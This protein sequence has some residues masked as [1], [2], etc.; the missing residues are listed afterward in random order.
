LFLNL[1]TAEWDFVMDEKQDQL[2]I[3]MSFE[4]IAVDYERE[5]DDAL[6]LKILNEEFIPEELSPPIVR[7][8]L[9]ECMEVVRIEGLLEGSKAE[10]FSGSEMIGDA[11]SHDGAAA[12]E[13]RPLKENENITAIQTFDTQQSPP[14]FPAIRVLPHPETLP[15]PIVHEPVFECSR[16]IVI[17]R[18]FVGA[19]AQVSVN[20][21]QVST[22]LI[23]NETQG[24]FLPKRLSRGD[25]VEVTI[26]LCENADK[27]IIKID[28]E[29]PARAVR[30]PNPMPPPTIDPKSITIGNK[31]I[32]VSDLVIG[33]DQTL[34]EKQSSTKGI[35]HSWARRA[36][37][38]LNRAIEDDDSYG[39]QQSLCV[40]SIFST[41]IPASS[42]N[43]DQNRLPVP[44]LGRPICPG[45]T[46]ARVRGVRP[47]AVVCVF[48]NGVL[49]GVA[50]AH[51]PNILVRLANSFLPN[52]GDKVTALQ[53]V[54]NIV[55]PHSAAV[56]AD[57]IKDVDIDVEG[58]GPHLD[59]EG[60]IVEGLF[61]EQTTTL[62]IRVKTCCDNKEAEDA[63]A[64]II[65]ETG[66]EFGPV[67]LSR[68]GSGLYE[69][70]LFS[71]EVDG[72]P[73][74]RYVVV[75]RGLCC[76]KVGE[77]EFEVLLSRIDLNDRTPPSLSVRATS[78][79]GSMVMST[80]GGSAPSNLDIYLFEYI[81]LD[82][83]AQ[84]FQGLKHV[85]TSTV[86]GR[87]DRT[88]GP[89]TFSASGAPPIPIRKQ[90]QIRVDYKKL[91]Q[92]F[93]TVSASNFGRFSTPV[94]TPQLTVN[95]L[96]REPHLDA[97]SSRRVTV[98]DKIDFS[99]RH[100]LVPGEGTVIHFK[101]MG[102]MILEEIVDPSIL[103]TTTIKG[104]DIPDSLQPGRYDVCVL[105]GQAKLMSNSMSIEVIKAKEPETPPKIT[106]VAVT[107]QRSTIWDGQMK[108]IVWTKSVTRLDFGTGFNS[109]YILETTNV[110]DGVV[111]LA[112]SEKSYFFSKNEVS[113]AF[114]DQTLVDF[115]AAQPIGNFNLAQKSTLV[116]KFKVTDQKP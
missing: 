33:A 115:W 2:N 43:P 16:F 17:K 96:Q 84:D 101:K 3:G 116:F 81:D 53:Y 58:T 7:A 27:D 113:N 69:G 106:N 108:K 13:T 93:I 112:N 35:Y 6:E 44:L 26:T 87:I 82:V 42:S 60:Q 9:F 114:K 94:N 51:S 75:V 71:E 104:L 46:I 47:G 79:S 40:D 72:L 62:R 55:S 14:S 110:N 111:E 36:W 20:G 28:A 10:V 38:L 65:S 63:Q 1:N 99:G 64:L 77:H 50:T 8:P 92:D 105:V 88:R 95:I 78:Q 15:T 83:E 12:V 18:A 4:R 34:L 109:F 73:A 85:A 5:N 48:V 102:M 61:D 74:G 37:F 32:I 90:L 100:F 56:V 39:A 31:R 91:G 107:L 45:D 86:I 67:T 23:Q 97:L 89:S 57:F 11:V 19:R 80:A 76:G 52:A 25:V 59:N 30:A 68:Y 21:Q 54:W 49:S 66:E 98:F 70:V 41:D 22:T 24:I 103:Q 29:N